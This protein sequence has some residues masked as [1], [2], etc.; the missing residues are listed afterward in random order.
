[1]AKS[2]RTGNTRT[3]KTNRKAT[4]PRAIKRGSARA[5]RRTTK[6][7][8]PPP[9]P[10]KPPGEAMY[11]RNAREDWDASEVRELKTLARDNT[12]TRVIGLKLGRSEK[13]VRAKASEEGLS[14]KPA[15]QSP[16]DRKGRTRSR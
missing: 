3:G 7:T 10:K 1:M 14:L 11:I 5:G 12:P 8:P 2:T 15:N 16:Y 4:S 6:R 13:A 9:P